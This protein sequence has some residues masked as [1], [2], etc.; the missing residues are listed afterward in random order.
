MAGHSQF[1][2]IMHRKGRQDAIKSKVFGKLA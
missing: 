2:N 1:K